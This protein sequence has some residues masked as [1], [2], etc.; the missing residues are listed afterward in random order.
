MRCATPAG[1]SR[2]LRQRRE[3]TLRSLYHQAL[4][5]ARDRQRIYSPKHCAAFSSLASG[6]IS[7]IAPSPLLAIHHCGELRFRDDYV[8]SVSAAGCVGALTA[9]YQLPPLSSFIGSIARLICRPSAGLIL[10]DEPAAAAR[11]HLRLAAICDV[12]RDRMLRTRMMLD[13]SDFE[14]RL[15]IFDDHLCLSDVH[16]TPHFPA[17]A[18]ADDVAASQFI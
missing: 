8:Y 9:G 12:G 10:P 15:G 6:R 5:S 17:T 7:L 2:P 11:R 4:A 13:A 18:L 16:F 14:L 1:I 3:M